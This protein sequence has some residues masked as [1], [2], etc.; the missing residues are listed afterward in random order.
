MQEKD[1]GKEGAVTGIPEPAAGVGEYLSARSAPAR[2]SLLELRNL[3]F[4]VAAED[5]RIGPLT[6]TLKWG[7]PAYLTS[8][9]GAGT[10]L[11]LAMKKGK[12]ERIGMF[13]H[14]QTRVAERIEELYPETFEFDGTRGLLFAPGAELPVEAVKGC[15]TLVLTYHLNPLLERA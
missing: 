5:P 1:A 15:M 14:C 11:R 2:E 10:T 4:Q 6:E 13:F 12:A 7:E 8:K 3:V 9:T